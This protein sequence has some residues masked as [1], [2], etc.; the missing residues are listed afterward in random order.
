MG[1]HVMPVYHMIMIHNLIMMMMMMMMILLP[2]PGPPKNLRC[3]VTRNGHR[4]KALWYPPDYSYGLVV[5]YIIRYKHL[6]REPRK[7]EW[8]IASVTMKPNTN[9]YPLIYDLDVEYYRR[10]RI[11]VSAVNAAGEGP[12]AIVESCVLRST[13]NGECSIIR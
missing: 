8:K 5:K 6:V 10:Y 9:G 11:E 2:G 12:A 4:A 1:Y 13:K 7:T 3:N